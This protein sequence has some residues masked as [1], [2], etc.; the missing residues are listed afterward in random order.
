LTVLTVEDIHWASGALLDL[1]EGLADT[2]SGTS[3]LVAC[4]ART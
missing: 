1:L 2:L 3:V 4:T